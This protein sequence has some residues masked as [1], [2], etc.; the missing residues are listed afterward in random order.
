MSNRLMNGLSFVSTLCGRNENVR[1]VSGVPFD[2]D[3]IRTA[4]TAKL[5]LV[6][7]RYQQ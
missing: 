2:E 5:P 6:R 3:F 7:P 4:P 1:S